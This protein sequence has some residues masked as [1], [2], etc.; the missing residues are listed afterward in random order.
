MEELKENGFTAYGLD[1]RGVKTVGMVTGDK[2][3]FALGAEGPGLRRLVK[4]N[5]DELVKLPTS[6]PIQ[7]L[8]VSNAAAIALY[9]LLTR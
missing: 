3:V 6:G 5:C 7:S 1:E 4:E 2:I 9:A 8:N